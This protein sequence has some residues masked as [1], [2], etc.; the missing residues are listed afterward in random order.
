MTLTYG[1]YRAIL[2]TNRSQADRAAA[3][4]AFHKLYEANANTY[5]SLYNGVLQRD[6]FV[7]AG[8]RLRIDARHGAPRQQHS[9]RRS[10]KT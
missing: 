2:A 8:A 10:S 3:F 7:R 4:T 6:W 9:D 5:A 1:Q